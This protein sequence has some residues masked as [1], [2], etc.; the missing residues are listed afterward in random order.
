MDMSTLLYFQINRYPGV[1]VIIYRKG[2]YRIWPP[3][4]LI[5]ISEVKF[6][7]YY[8]YHFIIKNYNKSNLYI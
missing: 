1:I 2:E 8:M 3:F 4:V 6:K 7:I 5:T